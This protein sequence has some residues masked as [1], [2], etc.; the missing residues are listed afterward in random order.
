MTPDQRTKL[1]RRIALMLPAVSPLPIA[2][3]CRAFLAFPPDPDE[4]LPWWIAWSAIAWGVLTLG[5]DAWLAC[6]YLRKHGWSG[7]GLAILTITATP[8]L[9]LSHATAVA[10][11]YMLPGLLLTLF[12]L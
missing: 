6:A 1:L 12:Y 10:V 7:A 8:G 4:F 9:L 5:C 2:L 3:A 11:L